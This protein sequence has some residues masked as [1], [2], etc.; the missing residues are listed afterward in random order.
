MIY[1]TFK[2]ANYYLEHYANYAKRYLRDVTHEIGAVRLK[3]QRRA[4]SQSIILYSQGEQLFTMTQC[5]TVNNVDSLPIED[6]IFYCEQVHK[7]HL[8]EEY[9]ESKETEAQNDVPSDSN[10]SNK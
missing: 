5:G 8:V 4:A 1:N 2:D 9:G 7:K 3:R 6:L 10:N